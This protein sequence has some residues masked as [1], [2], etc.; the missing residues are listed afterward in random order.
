MADETPKII[1]SS[2]PQEPSG[3]SEPVLSDPPKEPLDPGNLVRSEAPREPVDLVGNQQKFEPELIIGDTLDEVPQPPTL[4]IPGPPWEPTQVETILSGPPWNPSQVA[5]VPEP[6][7]DSPDDVPLVLTP[8]PASP[9]DVPTVLTPPPGVPHDVPTPPEPGPANP[10][11]VPT[12]LTPPPWEAVDVPTVLSGESAEPFDVPIVVTRDHRIPEPGE[13]PVQ[14]PVRVRDH[15]DEPGNQP[16]PDLLKPSPVVDKPDLAKIISQVQFIDKELAKHLNDLLGGL[17]EPISIFGPGGASLDP[18]VLARW[19][20]D[21]YSSVGKTGVA[22]FILQQTILYSKN[23]LVARIFD[24]LYFLKMVVPGTMGVMTTT[25]DTQAGATME[26]IIKTRDKLPKQIQETRIS[27]NTY[28]EENKYSDGQDFDLASMTDLTAAGIPAPLMSETTEAGVKTQKFDS[29]KYFIRDQK[30]PSRALINPIFRDNKR[31]NIASTKLAASVGI[32]GIIP[33]SI[34]G[35]N[36]DGVV[37]TKTDSPSEIGPGTNDVLGGNYIDDDTAYVPFSFTDLRPT[38]DGLFRSV[39]FR[40]FNLNFSRSTSPEF[41]EDGAFGRTDPVVGYIKTVRTFDV[42]FDLHAFI[43]E[44]VLTIHRKLLW[45][46]SMAYPTYS[47]DALLKSGPIC[48]MRIGDVVS[49]GRKGLPGVLKSVSVDFADAIWELRKGAKVPRSASVTLS[50]LALH[51]G[52]IG[53]L[54]GEFGVLSLPSVG[55][56]TPATVFSGYYQGFGEPRR[57]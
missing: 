11:D 7:P 27:E 1:Y 45:L 52:P 16:V 21:Y 40:P 19:L 53:H 48:R 43:P 47:S 38:P 23:P 3:V 8:P 41:E 4:S 37:L 42:S 35:E 13:Q 46:E 10:Y 17:I 24:P 6:P 32:N 55:E 54:D 2:P 50:F 57:K 51:E 9:Y 44:D 39:F 14:E 22:E 33:A 18:T 26:D 29:S 25:I 36:Q 20:R 56:S 15:R 28:S 34:P 5:I 30:S 31:S 12:G 49:S